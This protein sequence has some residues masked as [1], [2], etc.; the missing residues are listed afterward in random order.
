M[1]TTHEQDGLS[2]TSKPLIEQRRGSLAQMILTTT[3]S[4]QQSPQEVRDDPMEQDWPPPPP[5]SLASQ[6]IHGN[7]IPLG[8][9]RSSSCN[10]LTT[11]SIVG[12]AASKGH[13]VDRLLN[14]HTLYKIKRRKFH[15]FGSQQQQQKHDLPPAAPV[16]SSSSLPS[17]EDVSI[18]EIRR[19]G[20]KGMLQSKI[21]ICYFLYHLLQE[22]SSENLVSQIGGGEIGVTSC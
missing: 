17:L 12:G 1:A 19:E 18:A 7:S 14:V 2:F 22:I 15:L 11:P 5:P 16:V 4:L 21:P 20:V 13:G 6:S 3:S 8:R 9:R 10:M